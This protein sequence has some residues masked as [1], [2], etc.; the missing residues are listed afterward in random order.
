MFIY[1]CC[2]RGFGFVYHHIFLIIAVSYVSFV[3][4]Q[5]FS[6]FVPWTSLFLL[7]FSRLSRD[8]LFVHLLPS[9]P[10][11]N[12]P[13]CLTADVP[14]FIVSFSCPLRTKII[15]TDALLYKLRFSW[16]FPPN[17]PSRENFSCPPSP[18]AFLV[19]TLHRKAINVVLWS[20][21]SFI[22]KINW[23][24]LNYLNITVINLW[25]KFYVFCVAL[26]APKL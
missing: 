23:L 11:T 18:F 25:Q 16:R 26:W 2:S 15:M 19:R 17:L 12:L 24:H 22:I 20:L 7:S 14:V 6:D 10:V 1:N 13:V 4:L 8:F 3:F 21:T 9:L 5:L